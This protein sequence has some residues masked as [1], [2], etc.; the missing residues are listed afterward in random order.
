MSISRLD[1]P[2]QSSCFRETYLQRLDARSREVVRVFGRLLDGLALEQSL[3]QHGARE[4]AL[5]ELRGVALEIAEVAK[6]LDFLCGE[7]EAHP[8]DPTEPDLAAISRRVAQELE[9]ISRELQGAVE[10]SEKHEPAQPVAFSRRR[11][12]RAHLKPVPELPEG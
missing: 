7:I 11:A 4:D 8:V 2:E 3:T 12:R 5:I 9:E 10:R 6:G 1:A